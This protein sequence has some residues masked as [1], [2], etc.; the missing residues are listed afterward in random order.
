MLTF[1]INNNDE[2]TEGNTDINP[3]LIE[4]TSGTVVSTCLS[5]PTLSKRP[6]IICIE[7]QATVTNYTLFEDLN[8]V[9][10]PTVKFG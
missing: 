10:I 8:H 3:L 2:M 6:A 4:V 9:I 5:L 1:H 7:I